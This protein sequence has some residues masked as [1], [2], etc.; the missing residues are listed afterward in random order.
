MCNIVTFGQP[1]N[2]YLLD[3]PQSK[4]QYGLFN[5]TYKD[6]PF[7]MPSVSS[8]VYEG[9]VLFIFKAV[10]VL[11]PLSFTRTPLP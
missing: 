1:P 2:N 4:F 5:L 3:N 8:S 10:P 11:F 6:V 9:S 7:F